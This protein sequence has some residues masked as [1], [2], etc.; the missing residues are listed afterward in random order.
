MHVGLAALYVPQQDDDTVIILS[1]DNT[2]GGIDDVPIHDAN[3]KQELIL[4]IK[5][6]T[7]TL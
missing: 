7:F 1:Q 5:S 3:N 6:L 2:I 4:L